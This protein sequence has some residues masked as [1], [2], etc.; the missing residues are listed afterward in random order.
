MKSCWSKAC[1]GNLDFQESPQW[2]EDRRQPRN[3]V[4]RWS[5]TWIFDSSW[6]LA[7][8]WAN[9][10]IYKSPTAFLTRVVLIRL[11]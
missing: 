4:S 2:P 3:F 6:L 5:A 10:G 11:S 9:R 8:S 1:S 7:S